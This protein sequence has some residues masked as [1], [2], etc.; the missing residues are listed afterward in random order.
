MKGLLHKL[1]PNRVPNLS[2]LAWLVTGVALLVL[3]LLEFSVHHHAHFGWDDFFGFY[4][5]YGF[6]A[7]A[8]LV[9]LGNLLAK[10]L[11]RPEDYY[12]DDQET[13]ADG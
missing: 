11:K 12:A 6:I 10:F 3:I 9:I 5:V 13:D 8:G 7:S 2:P 1:N 4:A